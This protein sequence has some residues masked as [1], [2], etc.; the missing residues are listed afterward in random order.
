MFLKEIELQGFKSFADKTKIEF[1]RGV[2]AIVGPN[3]SGKSNITES[4]RWALGESSAKSLRG[5][6]MP[7]VIF[8]GTQSRKALNYA[9][10]AVTLDNSDQ[11]IE[12]AS[13]LIRVE[14]RIF[15]NGDSEYL[16][17]GRKVRLRDVHELFMDT[18][19]GRDSFSIIS[20]GR[21]EEI[22]NSKPQ[23]RRAIFEEAAGVLKYKTR[24]KETQTKLNQTQDNLDRLEDIIY[25]LDTQVTPLKKQAETAQCFLELEGERKVLDLAILVEDIKEQKL[26]LST[27]KEELAAVKESLSAYYDK[28]QKLEDKSQNLKDRRRKLSDKSLTKQK[29]LLDV[30]QLSADLERQIEV[31]QLASDQ[32]TQKA[33]QLTEQAKKLEETIEQTKTALNEKSASLASLKAKLEQERSSIARLETDLEQYRHNPDQLIEQL[34]EQFVDVMQKEAE[35]SNQKTALK[36]QKSSQEQQSAFRQEEIQQLA[37]ELSKLKKEEANQQALLEDASQSVKELL[38][39][40]QEKATALESAEATYR[41]QQDQLFKQLDDIKS[42]KAK[43]ASLESIYKNHSHFYAGVKA[44]LQ[45][46]SLT[47]IIGAVSEHIS[48]SPRYQTALEIALGA[49]SQHII[50]E[51]ENAAKQAIAFLKQNR[52]GRA[53]F[54]PLTTISSRQLASHQLET[55][56]TSQGFSGIASQLVSYEPK[57]SHIMSNLLGLTAI[58]DSIEHANQAAKRL[59]YRVRI[60]TLDGTEIRAGGSFSGGANRGNNTTFIKQELD[61]VEKELKT[62]EEKQIA[63]EKEVASLKEKLESE[64]EKLALIKEEGNQKRLEEQAA[65]LSYKQVTERLSDVEETYQTL[66]GHVENESEPAFDTLW[67]ELE[68]ELSELAQKK[69]ALSQQIEQLKTDKDSFDT[70]VARLSEQLSQAKLQ[71]RELLSEMKF[72]KANQSRLKADLETYQTELTSLTAALSQQDQ[73]DDSLLPRLKAQ[74]E[75]AREHKS[76]LEQEQI[77]LRFELEDLEAQIDETNQALAKE[78]QQNEQFIRKQAQIEAMIET[79]EKQLRQFARRLSEEYQYTLEDAKEKAHALENLELA[80]EQLRTLQRQIKD[81]GPVNLDAIEQFEEVSQRLDFLNTQKEDLVDAKNLLLTTISDMDE[82]VKQRFKLTFEAIRESFKQTFTQMFG[83]GSADLMLTSEDLLEAGIEI[84]VQPPGKKIQSLNLMSGGEKALSALA[85]LFAIIRVKTIPFVILDEV[86]AALDEANVKRFGDYLNRFDQSS[87]FI[88]VTHRK[89]TMAAA[90]SIYGVTMQESG[91]SRIVSVK[92]KDAE[93][94][95]TA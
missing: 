36:A 54:L 94:L 16:I 69:S 7:D 75:Q 65:Q 70:G 30:T 14:R 52:R 46:K 53:T 74:L 33:A 38:E 50:V 57:L 24:K 45:E 15:R 3:G 60:V 72:E 49:S 28:R 37:Q 81:L 59:S 39:Q 27:Q 91:V 68:E 1:D 55:L 56:E 77:S 83:G 64:R 31:T 80:R 95:T 32:S 82:E 20:Q 18:G 6:K 4:L 25:E 17:D 42:K 29:E 26:A 71:E 63:H 41:T 23:E 86:E 9:Y 84:S 79:I 10:V 21:V 61:Q 73:A 90:D 66:K 89:G 88:V 40:Y 85:L 67:Q 5:G 44:V 12:Q 78:S 47:G 51:D 34:R 19:L 48:F 35:L 11:F 58:F 13:E 92:L 43:K 93:S 76:S 22:F 2:T 62:L 8:A 87:Q